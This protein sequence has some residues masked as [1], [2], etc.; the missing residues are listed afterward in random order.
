MLSGE[1]N[2]Y[3]KTESE[4]VQGDPGKNHQQQLLE[5]K[6]AIKDYKNCVRRSQEP[7]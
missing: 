3:Y 2:G 7:T 6:E 4:N 1:R 5:S